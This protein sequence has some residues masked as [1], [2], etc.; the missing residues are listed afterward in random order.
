MIDIT[1]SCNKVTVNGATCI[2]EAAGTFFDIIEN[3]YGTVEKQKL[4][5]RSIV[6]R[7]FPVSDNLLRPPHNKIYYRWEGSNKYSFYY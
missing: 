7:L 2:E 4:M 3:R 5:R 1:P 6:R